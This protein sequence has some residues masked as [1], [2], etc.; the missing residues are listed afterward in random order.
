[1][2]RLT[3]CFFV[4][5][6]FFMLSTLAQKTKVNSIQWKIAGGLPATNG[7]SKALGF[8]GPIAG[9][10]NGVLVVAG[11]SN[12]PDSMPW[13]GGKKNIMMMCMFI[14]KK[15]KGSSSTKNIQTF[16]HCSLCCYLLYRT[17][18]CIRRR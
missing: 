18:H 4:A 10:H 11:G 6:Q 12:F 15:I 17:R 2:I 9:V 7:Q 3:I 1:M 14:L 5:L 13:L 8:A 16:K